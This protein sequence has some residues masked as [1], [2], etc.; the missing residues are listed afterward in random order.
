MTGVLSGMSDLPMAVGEKKWGGHSAWLGLPLGIPWEAMLRRALELNSLQ[1]VNEYL[2]RNCSRAKSP[3]P[4]SVSIHVA[5]S[6]QKHNEIM[7][8][9]VGYNYSKAFGPHTH[10]PS[11]THPD[12]DDVV[13][14]SKNDPAHTS[15]VA[16]MLTAQYGKIDAEWLAMYYSPND[17]TGDTQVVGFDLQAMKVYYANSRKSTSN[18]PLCAY[19]RQRTLLDMAAIFA[20]PKP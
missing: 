3:T 7:G 15:C 17:M 5:F 19:Y 14:W 18:G 10:S 8:Y 6:D 16:E 13:Y 1:A 11:A 9:E 20:E 12:F 2:T 4:N